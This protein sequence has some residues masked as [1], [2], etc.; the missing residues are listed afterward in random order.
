MTVELNALQATHIQQQSWDE[1]VERANVAFDAHSFVKWAIGDIVAE[2]IE[3]GYY[4]DETLNKFR[5]ESNAPYISNRTLQD[6]AQVS[7]FYPQDS[8][9]DET[10]L[11]RYTHYRLA[12]QWANRAL[13]LQ[14]E[15]FLSP[16]QFT[17]LD[18]ALGKLNEWADNQVTCTQAGYLRAEWEEYITGASSTA[19]MHTIH[20]GIF[21]RSQIRDIVNALDVGKQYELTIKVVG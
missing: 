14:P 11:L 8:R 12:M 3:G 21:S 5:I 10:S 20:E 19:P 17:P 15:L 6:H 1:L 9:L 7:R 16:E 4:G 18:Y 13:I 2:V